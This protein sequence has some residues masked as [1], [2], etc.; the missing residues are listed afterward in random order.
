[1]G[2]D[3]R[4]YRIILM[5]AILKKI[6]SHLDGIEQ[7]LPSGNFIRRLTRSLSFSIVF[8]GPSPPDRESLPFK[9]Q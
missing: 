6:P 5:A 9:L 4:F 1:M 2:R 8:L 7:V 3:D